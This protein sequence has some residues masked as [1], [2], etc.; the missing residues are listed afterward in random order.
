MASPPSSCTG[1]SLLASTSTRPPGN[2]RL[3]EIDSKPRL[4]SSVFSACW[5]MRG[6]GQPCAVHEFPP[7]SEERRVGKECRSRGARYQSKKEERRLGASREGEKGQ[8]QREEGA[9][10]AQA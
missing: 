6:I 8:A 3:I 1:W 2:S 10:T 4:A 7:R 5:L 9:R